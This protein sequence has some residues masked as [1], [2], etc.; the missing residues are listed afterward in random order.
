LTLVKGYIEALNDG[1]FGPQD[2]K[3]CYEKILNETRGLERLVKDL[4]ELSRLQTGNI[5]LEF[6]KV[7]IMS[8]VN[9]V[10]KS[11]QLMAQNKEISIQLLYEPETAQDSSIPDVAGD[12]DRLRQ[13]IIIFMD[14]ALKFSP[15]G[16]EINVSVS[17]DELV[18]ITIEDNGPGIAKDDLEHI[19]DRFY[20]A[21][22]SRTGRNTG[23]G[24]GLSIA[25]HLVELHKGTVT[26]ES[27]EN[28]GT[29]VIIGLP[30]KKQDDINS[31]VL[32]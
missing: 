5:A 4:T 3:G 7:D 25:K 15:P 12:Y 16:S 14:N 10:V 32:K 28:K 18:Y 21:D 31:G 23:S 9:D 20:K 30:F 29:R 27:V 11:M 8:L 1:V 19:W 22:K 6:S 24:L 26:I 17:V 2:A 13:L